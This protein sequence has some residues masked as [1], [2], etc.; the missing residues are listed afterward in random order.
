MNKEQ[1]DLLMKEQEDYN[2][3]CFDSMMNSLLI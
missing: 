2:Y 3:Q 1:E